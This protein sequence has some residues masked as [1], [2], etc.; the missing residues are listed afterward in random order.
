MAGPIISVDDLAAVIGDPEVHVVDCRWYLVEPDRGR[1]E[2]DAGHLPG[3]VYVSL[4]E[5]MSGSEGPG[6]HPLPDP[7]SFAVSMGALG[8]SPSDRVVAYDDRGGAIAARLWWMLSAQGFDGVS[9]LD[10]GIPAW[11]AAGHP[12]SATPPNPV[13]VD[14]FDPRPWTG[15]VTIDQV[16]ERAADA[17]L[18]DARDV[19]RYRGDAEPVDSKAGHIPGARSLPLTDLLTEHGRFV[20]IPQVRE[21]FASVGFAAGGDAVAQCGSG[22]TACH[23]ILAAEAAG[24]GRPDLY[25]GSWSD[26]S[27]TDRPVATGATP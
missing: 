11:I 16:A 18:L 21:S 17:V 26:W 9:V 20:G 10:G 27:S 4:D 13:P 3:A 5:H 14:P 15:T 6:R 12:I 22:V 25:V 23:L 24:L 7:A 19:E 1:S 2:Y 8:L